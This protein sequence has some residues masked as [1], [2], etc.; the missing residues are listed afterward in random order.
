LITSIE[1]YGWFNVNATETRNPDE[2]STLFVGKNAT[3]QKIQDAI[4]DAKNGDTIFVYE[5][6]YSEKLRINKS[7]SL[8]GESIDS[9]I[10]DSKNNTLDLINIS[11][12]NVNFTN[13]HIRCDKNNFTQ[14][15]VY[16]YKANNC[17]ISDNKLSHNFYN[18]IIFESSNNS[19]LFNNTINTLNETIY[20]WNSH[21]NY[22][23]NNQIHGNYY[24]CITMF[25]SNHNKFIGN[26]ISRGQ[27]PINLKFSN[28]NTFIN[29]SILKFY[30]SIFLEQSNANTFLK[31]YVRPLFSDCIKLVNSNKNNFNNN[32]ISDCYRTF[33]FESSDN[34]S[35][36]KNKVTNSEYSAWLYRANFTII[37]DNNFKGV[38]L[39]IWCFITIGNVI[40]NNIINTYSGGNMIL[41]MTKNDIVVNNTMIGNGIYLWEH[42]SKDSVTLN[43]DN[44]NLINGRPIY[45]LKNKTNKKVPEDAGQ[46]ILVNC[47]DIEVSNIINSKSGGRINVLF[48]SRINISNNDFKGFSIDSFESNNISINNNSLSSFHSNVLHQFGINLEDCNNA[49]IE[50]NYLNNFYE[51][52]FLRNSK[53]NKIEKN[54]LFNNTH[55]IVLYKSPYNMIRNNLI[56]ET[57]KDAIKLIHTDFDFIINNQIMYNNNTGIILSGSSNNSLKFNTIAFNKGIGLE[58]KKYSEFPSNNNTIFH[59]NFINNNL[60]K[61]YRNSHVMDECTNHWDSG[62]PNGG[63]FWSDYSGIDEM[64]GIKQD[65]HGSDGIGDTPLIINGET[66]ILDRYPLM[67]PIYGESPTTTSIPNS[68]HNFQAKSGD[69]FVKLTWSAPLYDGNLEIIKYHIRRWN[70]GS[71][72]SK[73]NFDINNIT[74]ILNGKQFDYLDNDVI[75]GEIYHYSISAENE[76]GIGPNSSRI[77]GEPS[78]LPKEPGDP[79]GWLGIS[80]NTRLEVVVCCLI[81]VSLVTI[82]IVFGL[83]KFYHSRKSKQKKI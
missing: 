53:Y 77:T 13:F 74:I 67:N 25:K 27:K 35:I 51:G 12:D 56:C 42:S 66:N 71:N 33:Y 45:F 48:S 39:G 23:I 40:K 47:S 4:D 41:D 59:N 73:W 2:N 75:N 68:P 76:M 32:N 10:I 6:L 44:T 69:G 83:V 26:I 72:N 34:N 30:D 50:N 38:D 29:N 79:G 52:I 14:Y 57:E 31:N 1:S 54:R 5:G 8:I 16:L 21:S 70:I 19:S 11:S 15:A 28:N 82:L 65:E 80:W 7:I 81:L 49:A 17:N 58:I 61:F 60:N 64:K 20:F 9:T 18:G 43:I 62:Y 78:E 24:D 46:V 3:Y 36:I 55:G 63:N 37:S 22:F